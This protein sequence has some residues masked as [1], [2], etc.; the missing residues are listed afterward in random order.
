MTV[1]HTSQ[2]R[3]GYNNGSSS[4]IWASG[5]IYRGGHKQLYMVIG[6]RAFAK[7]TPRDTQKVHLHTSEKDKQAIETLKKMSESAMKKKFIGFEGKLFS[8][9]NT[10]SPKSLAEEQ[11][12]ILT[13]VSE[14][15][16]YMP[17]VV[18]DMPQ[19]KNYPATIERIDFS[20]LDNTKRTCTKKSCPKFGK[21]CHNVLHMGRDKKS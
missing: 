14:Q 5:A 1:G 17:G 21:L 9:P 10:F 16:F 12:G 3:H 18:E 20:Y 19:I 6:E 11:S 7:Q 4:W 8:Y 2:K 13:K 15:K